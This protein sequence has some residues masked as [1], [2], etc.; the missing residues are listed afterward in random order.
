MSG[1]LTLVIGGAA[2]GKSA[3][4]EDLVINSG[5]PMVYIATAEAGDGEMTERIA[6]HRARRG[7]GWETREN[8]LT[9][10]E[11]L[12]ALPPDRAVL[13]DCATMWLTN[14]MMR[15]DDP[16]RAEDEF[17]AALAACRAEVVVVTNEVG[18]GIVP[19]HALSRRFREAQG[20][21]NIRLAAQADRVVQ[22]VA[23][24]PLVLKGGAG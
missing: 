9:P 12:A 24:L 11:E 19:E 2:S 6:I 4:A 8:P 23:G 21:L 16:A 15:G 7:I 22:V 18:Q 5:L 1:P 17:L 13:L 10:G 14:Q 20:R 3:Y